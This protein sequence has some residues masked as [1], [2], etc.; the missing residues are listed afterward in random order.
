MTTPSDEASDIDVD[1][2]VLGAGFTGVYLLKRLREL[3]F[4][5]RAFEAGSDV[6][7]TW[8]WNRY[9]GARCDSEISVYNFSE[10][11][12]PELAQ[13]W[14]WS[15]RFPSQPEMYSYL[16]HA[17]DSTGLR[18]L[19]TFDTRVTSAVFDEHRDLWT[20]T[21]DSGEALRSRYFVPAVGPL[22]KPNIPSFDGQDQF[23][24]E[25]YH[26]AR[27]PADFDMA[28]RRLAVIGSGATAVQIVPIAASSAQHVYQLQRTASHCLP[29]RNHRLDADDY[30]EIAENRGAIW[31]RARENPV[32]QPYAE[33]LGELA[34]FDSERQ[35][36]IME[37]FW[38]IGGLTLCFASFSDLLTNA[39]ANRVVLDFLGEKIRGIVR[40]PDTAEKLTPKTFFLTKRPPI[41]HGYY[42]AFNRDNVSLIDIRENPID[43][44][45]PNGIKLLNGDV[46]D[47]DVV[48]LAT[49]FDALTGGLTDIDIRGVGGESLADHF[50]ERYDSYLGISVS[51]YPN[52]FIAYSGPQ[53]P[54][55]LSNG[56]TLIEEHG[57][58]IVNALTWLRERQIARVDVRLAAQEKFT[59]HNAEV[60][61]ATLIPQTDS[62]WTGANIEGKKR[63][64]PTFTEGVPA[65]LDV[66]RKASDGYQDYDLTPS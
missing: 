26:T 29:G 41:E 56:P 45:V 3:G 48:L 51:G 4:T 46:L 37:M 66:L 54:A 8:Y 30:A 55:V 16:R 36:E 22:S 58:W 19:I 12:N 25:I 18:D 13:T 38:N 21:T 34:T 44:L 7:G 62:W 23:T 57:E 60:V 32:G 9:P 31:T 10:R 40:D 35:R 59:Q 65:Y 20:V 33:S 28:G 53:S 61:A 49:G 15:E 11:F 17:V 42:E 50:R 47:V 39:D 2:V 63:G 24:G 14:K 27:M 43:S 52:M 64:F 1:V 6:G 5:V